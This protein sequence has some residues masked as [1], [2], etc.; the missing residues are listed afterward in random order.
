MNAFKISWL[1]YKNNLKLYKF[2]LGVLILA[3]AIYYNF[4]AV[5][6]NPYLQVLGEQYIFAQVASALLT[7]KP[8]QILHLN[9]CSH[10]TP[11]QIVLGMILL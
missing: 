11:P 9:N 5:N 8:G 2:Y 3:T 1:L 7:E 4:L 6:Y 10:I